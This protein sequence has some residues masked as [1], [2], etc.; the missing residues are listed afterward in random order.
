MQQISRGRLLPS[1]YG[2]GVVKGLSFDNTYPAISRL[3]NEFMM[4]RPYLVDGNG[5]ELPPN[6]VINCIYNP[7]AD[8]SGAKFREALATMALVHPKV[9]LLVWRRQG[10]NSVE[11][12][13]ITVNNLAGFTFLE[14]VSEID[15]GHNKRYF[16][17]GKTYGADD[18]ITI[19]I[20]VNPYNLGG[21]YSPSTAI[22]QWSNI[23][24]YIVAYQAGFFENG[25]V[26][27][28]QFIITTRTADEFNQIVDDMQRHHRGAGQNN[29]VMYT[30]RPV[31][32][33]TGQL[34]QP[35][36]QWVSFGNNN[37]NL[38][39]AE[40]FSRVDRKIDSAFG[41]PA[42]IRGVN[43]NNTYASVRVDEQVFLRYAVRPLATKIWDNFTSEL[44]RLTGGLG[45][46]IGFDID[47]VAVA[48]EQLTVANRKTAE[49]NLI[50][51]AL[52]N[53]YTLQSVID[54]FELSESYN[55]L[56]LTPSDNP[57]STVNNNPPPPI[58]Q[59]VTAPTGGLNATDTNDSETL[60]ENSNNQATKSKTVQRKITK[61]EFV[62]KF[63]AALRSIMEQQVADGLHDFEINKSDLVT[64]YDD[65]TINAI[66]TDV[67]DYMQQVGETAYGD[68][69]K[70]LADAGVAT[71][72]IE[73]FLLSETIKDNYHR[74]LKHIADGYT[75][76][77]AASIRLVLAMAQ[78]K[79]LDKEQ[80]ADKLREFMDDNEWRCQRMAIT[81]EHRI[82]GDASNAAMIQLSTVSNAKIIKTWQTGGDK[83]C[84]YCQ[85]M[86][87][88]QGVDVGTSFVRKGEQVT[89]VNSGI[90]D[91]NFVDID[92]ACLHPHCQCYVQYKVV[93]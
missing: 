73:R 72:P 92:S 59:P 23:D 75:K 65:E 22:S 16:C 84:E 39:M 9:Y 14:G 7:N 4:T 24:D 10:K 76:E 15:D 20:G 70:L 62:R 19:N 83:P 21:G 60:V 11:G 3:A 38:S 13:K 81:E 36:I 35:Q 87:Q 8:M 26:P 45:F 1:Y 89:G 67:D 78:E 18:V 55:K 40:I 79:D 17:G 46:A 30:H 90:F 6:N 37:D 27:A 51:N 54:A 42:S 63:A 48:D 74:Y 85:A 80:I 2:G 71:P 52:N 33:T 91:N 61:A 32:A 86:A 5:K 29:N 64:A 57:A 47:D 34:E 88:R 28:G 56:K 58:S 43:D 93:S 77:N 50:V 82:W 53:G 41:V 12:G 69:L 31:S 68:G 66:V 49:F 25:A 44:N